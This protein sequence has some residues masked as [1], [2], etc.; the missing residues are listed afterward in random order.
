[1]EEIGHRA[2]LN[3]SSWLVIYLSSLK[4]AHYLPLNEISSSS[5]VFFFFF[6]L[7]LSFY[8]LLCDFSPFWNR[9][10]K[11]WWQFHMNLSLIL[12]EFPVLEVKDL[13]FLGRL[14][15]SWLTFHGGENWISFLINNVVLP[16]L[17]CLQNCQFNFILFSGGR[18]K[19]N[20][21]KFS[22]LTE[23]KYL[24]S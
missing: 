15:K 6:L 7:S 23:Y 3:A 12:L 8:F 9:N 4:K 13:S 16:K 21:W 10:T 1:M 11:A 24:T 20:L 5:I 22:F 17:G 18:E 2:F 19:L 14:H